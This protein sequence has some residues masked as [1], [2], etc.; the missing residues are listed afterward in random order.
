MKK[1]SKLMIHAET[2]TQNVLGIIIGF[3]LLHLFGISAEQS[4][5]IQVTFFVVSYIRSY[6]IRSFFSKLE[7]KNDQSN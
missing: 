2:I 1:T 6:L 4:V 3:A 5:K 7:S